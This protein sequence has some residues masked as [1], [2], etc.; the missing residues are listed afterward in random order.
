MP[1]RRTPA[2]PSG[3]KP[4][5]AVFAGPTATI[6]N[7]LPLVT[8]NKAAEKY[9]LE[10]VVGRD[11][12]PLPFDALRP[13]RLAAPVKVYIEQFSAHPL[14]ADMAELYAPPDGYLAPDGTFRAQRTSDADKPVYE[15]ELRPEDGLYPLPYLARQRDG[16]PWDLDSTDPGAPPDRSR[17]PFYPD[18]SRLFEE[19]DRFDLDDDGLVGQLSSRA[20]YDFYRPAPSGGYRKGLPEGRRTDQGVGD[21]APEAWGDDFWPYRPPHL[22][23]EPPPGRLA[24]LTNEVRRVMTGGRY[25]GAIWLEGSPHVEETAYWLNL[26]VPTDRPIVCLA[27]HMGE[28][29]HRNVIDAAEYIVSGIWKDD[30]GRDS[31]GVVTTIDEM[32]IT[33]REVQKADDR[34]GGYIATGGHGG[35]V[36]SMGKPGPAVLTFR[37]NRRHTYRSE[38]GLHR[39]PRTVRGWSRGAD[40]RL[41]G[42]EVPVLDT[43]GRLLEAAIPKVSIFKHARYDES[44]LDASVEIEILGRM[45][46]NLAHRPLAGFVAEAAVPYGHVGPSR[47]A[48]IRLAILQGMP[49]VKVGRGNAE[50]F[51]PSVRVASA[52][53]GGNL[54]ATKAR[55]LLMACLLRF[56]ALP[57]ATDPANPTEAELEASRQALGDYQRVFDS[58]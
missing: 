47:D 15:V 54:T 58:H 9:G 53:A 22:R 23:R 52:I 49:V 51:V 10:R 57:V 17:L 14:E 11:G 19:I 2:Q 43:D 6:L 42:V 39:L 16:R 24:I 27:G 35:V 30:D 7:S 38:V 20:D 21:I 5:I 46:H 56:G 33:S 55:L 34:P 41:E 44:A 37:P 36:G 25:A 4:R 50:G 48:A 45:E 32:I 8:G 3:P 12:R 29:G 1:V 13:Q 31:V 18:A 26:L 28:L 40:G